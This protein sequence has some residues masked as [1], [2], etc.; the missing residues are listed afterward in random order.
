MAKLRRYTNFEALKL[1]VNL[2]DVSTVKRKKSLSEFEAFLNLLR[3]EYSN[4]KK[5]K[6]INGK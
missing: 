2:R 5:I 1:D 3:R 4:K 6:S